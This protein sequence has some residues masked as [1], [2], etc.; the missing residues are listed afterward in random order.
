LSDCEDVSIME[1]SFINIPCQSK[2]SSDQRCRV[3]LSLLPMKRIRSS[4]S[5]Y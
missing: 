2:V 4:T 5:P 3:R 1:E